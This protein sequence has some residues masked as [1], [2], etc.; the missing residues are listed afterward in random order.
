MPVNCLEEGPSFSNLNKGAY[1]GLVV[2]CGGK[3][4]DSHAGENTHGNK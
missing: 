4:D 2:G 1:D 3:T